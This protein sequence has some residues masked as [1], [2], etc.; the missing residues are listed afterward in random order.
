MSLSCP[1][2]VEAPCMSFG[3]WDPYKSQESCFPCTH[4]FALCD[5]RRRHRCVLQEVLIP[6][7]PKLSFE[8]LATFL[9]MFGFGC[10]NKFSCYSLCCELASGSDCLEARGSKF[11]YGRGNLCGVP[12]CCSR[13]TQQTVQYLLISTK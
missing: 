2:K 12:I 4:T 1:L 6:Y 3:L 5:Q 7:S 8:A 9:L 10:S 11:K 13:H